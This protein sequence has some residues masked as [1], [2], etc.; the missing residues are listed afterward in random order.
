MPYST[1]MR[2]ATNRHFRDAE[3]LFAGGGFDNAGYHYGFSAECALKGAMQRVGLRVDEVEVDGK[4]AYF[5]HF[6]ELKRIP[7]L[8]AGRL[9][10]AIASVLLSAQFLQNW[11]VKMHYSS[12]YEVTKD[13]CERWRSQVKYFNGQCGGI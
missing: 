2:A 10:Q 6:P 13:D 4:K 8:Y 1:N 5:K 9:S 11:D 3:A 7:V 12:D